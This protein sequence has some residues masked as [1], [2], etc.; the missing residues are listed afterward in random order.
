MLAA[1]W[2]VMIAN[3]SIIVTLDIQYLPDY[4]D[5]LA[6]SL[7]LSGDWTVSQI[8]NDAASSYKEGS[9]SSWL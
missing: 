2:L 4:L 5:I 6:Q 8:E 3:H 7:A 9:F 1:G